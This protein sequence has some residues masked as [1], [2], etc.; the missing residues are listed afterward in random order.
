MADRL[1]EIRVA[2]QVIAIIAAVAVEE[3]LDVTVRSG[4][5]Y[6][7]LAKKL[8]GGAKGIT[9]AVTEDRVIVDM[10]VSVR[11]GAQIHRVCHTL[12]EKVKEAVESLTGLFVEAVN[13]R[14]ETIE[15][16]K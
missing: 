3:V 4:G 10:R 12:Q 14:V 15:L 1:G 2:D 6:Q 13:V 5:L 8:N 7:D 16:G 11:Y 9:V